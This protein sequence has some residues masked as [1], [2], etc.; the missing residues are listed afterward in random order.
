LNNQ[1]K[2]N[3]S[4]GKMVLTVAAIASLLMIAMNVNTW[5]ANAIDLKSLENDDDIGPSVECV[6]VV[7]G[8]NGQGSVGSDRDVNVGS[9]DD[10]NN[11]NGRSGPIGPI[12]PTVCEACF[13]EL[14][15]AQEEALFTALDVANFA[16]VCL[17]IEDLTAETLL[18]LLLSVDVDLFVALDILDC[19]GIA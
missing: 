6:K 16:E 18:E 14:S 19:L 11:T 13:A 3:T 2:I 15:N 4:K 5:N 8:C 7:L 9:G 12:D 10:D 17:A 1:S